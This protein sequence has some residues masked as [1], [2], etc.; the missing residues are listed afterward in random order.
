MSDRLSVVIGTGFQHVID[1]YFWYMPF[2]SVRQ[3]KHVMDIVAKVPEEE[4]VAKRNEIRD[5]HNRPG[6]R[7][8]LRQ[9]F[10]NWI[11]CDFSKQRRAKALVVPVSTKVIEVEE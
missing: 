5:E 10:K 1:S 4:W 9:G 11:A 8:D 6:A 2:C 3:C 7:E